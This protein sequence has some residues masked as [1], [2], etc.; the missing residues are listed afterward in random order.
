MR[1]T[2]VSLVPKSSR[3]EYSGAL[4][5]DGRI[6]LKFVLNIRNMRELNGHELIADRMQ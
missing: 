4:Q 3:R 1:N 6:I 2:F 5:V